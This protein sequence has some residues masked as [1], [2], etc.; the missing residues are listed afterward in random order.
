AV[1]HTVGAGIVA[2]GGQ[3][4]AQIAKTPALAVDDH[5]ALRRGMAWS[6]SPPSPCRQASGAVIDGLN[7]GK[8]FDLVA[9]ALVAHAHADVHEELEEAFLVFQHVAPERR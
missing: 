8:R 2:G 7:I 4:D 1:G 9:L 5:G 3:A 6:I